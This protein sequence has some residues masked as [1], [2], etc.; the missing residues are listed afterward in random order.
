MRLNR[1]LA[2]ALFGSASVML[3]QSESEVHLF[4]FVAG[5][6]V[7]FIDRSGREVLPPQFGNA[8]DAARFREGLANAATPAGSGYVDVTGRF[9]VPA[10][11]W[12][13]A[14]ISEGMGSVQL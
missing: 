10:V 13:A 11:Y 4:P 3:A 2:A 9:A 14:P 1:L 12:W 6:K 8:G 7:G 5:G